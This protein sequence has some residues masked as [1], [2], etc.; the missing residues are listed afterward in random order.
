MHADDN[1]AKGNLCKI[2]SRIV[3]DQRC[4]KNGENYEKRSVCHKE[5][6]RG[7]C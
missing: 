3:I 1:V 6:D 5:T 4:T 7:D 2:F